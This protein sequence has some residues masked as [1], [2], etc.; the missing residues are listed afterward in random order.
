ML[1]APSQQVSSQ[2]QNQRNFSQE[3]SGLLMHGGRHPQDSFG[4]SQTH[5]GLDFGLQ[6][7]KRG[8][9]TPEITQ[10]CKHEHLSMLNHMLGPETSSINPLPCFEEVDSFEMVSHIMYDD[11]FNHLLKHN[12]VQ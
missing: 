2:L 12:K 7:G 6:G 5:N 8:L 1:R 10:L 4:P 9:L 3:P 11:I